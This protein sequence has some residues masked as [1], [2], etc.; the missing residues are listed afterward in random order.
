MEIN[1]AYSSCHSLMCCAFVSY[2]VMLDY[3]RQSDVVMWEMFML[4]TNHGSPF[5]SME[6]QF[7][8]ILC[9]CPIYCMVYNMFFG[10]V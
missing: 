8:V 2:C 6:A 9:W 5:G 3:L 7:G 4:Y 1:Q 10:D